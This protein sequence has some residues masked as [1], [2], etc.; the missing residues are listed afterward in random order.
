MHFLMFVADLPAEVIKKSLNFDRKYENDEGSK[1]SSP[2]KE[3]VAITTEDKSSCM[4]I[5]LFLYLFY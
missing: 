4:N 2:E 5:L 3:T 1:S